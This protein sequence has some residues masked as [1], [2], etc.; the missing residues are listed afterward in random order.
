M[1]RDRRPASG[2]RRL[3]L[4]RVSG[5]ALRTL[6]VAAALATAAAGCGGTGGARPG[7][8]GHARP[9][10]HAQR[11]AR[12]HLLDARAQLRRGRGR[13]AARA[14]AVVLHGLGEAAAVRADR[15]RDPRHPR[16]G[17]RARQGQRPRRRHGARRAPAGGGHRPARHPLARASSRA[18][19]WA[20]PGCR[21]TTPCCESVVAGRRR[22]PGEG[23]Q[24][25]D[26]LQRRAEPPRPGAS[27]AR[28]RS[29]TP[30]ASRSG[31]K[32]PD[33]RE[34]RVDDFGA[35]SYPELVVCATRD[36][37]RGAA[38]PRRAE[39]SAACV[40]GYGVTVHDPESSASDLVD[41]VKGLERD[42]RPEGARRADHR[43]R[44]RR[45]GVRRAGPGAPA[46][47][48]GVGEALRRGRRG[49]GRRARVR[50]LVPARLT[51]QPPPASLATS[52]SPSRAI[53][54]RGHD[55]VEAGLAAPVAARARPRGSRRPAFACRRARAPSASTRPASRRR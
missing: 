4:P 48:G 51:G 28:P 15:L 38:R 43:V 23:P 1:R 33:M 22:R 35:P 45:E 55:H 20:S 7:G 44:R 13:P 25:H 30:R 2:R 12:R 26:R 47:M 11:R 27:R 29:G 32:R 39:S 8:P 18:S 52:A 34:F 24:G 50:R 36:H 17:D 6:A 21:P 9:R 19:G 37:G 54:E 41:S 10:L 16:P 42:A 31:Q 3:M 49:A 53:R 5:R 14:P 46:G 40:R